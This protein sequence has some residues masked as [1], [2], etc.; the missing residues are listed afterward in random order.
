MQFNSGSIGE[1]SLTYQNIKNLSLKENSIR[2]LK[3]TSKE[4]SESAE[5]S[6]A[7]VGANAEKKLLQEVVLTQGRLKLELKI[8][9]PKEMVYVI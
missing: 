2:N 3:K 7:R 6:V 1:D 5:I 9:H 8:F 4:N